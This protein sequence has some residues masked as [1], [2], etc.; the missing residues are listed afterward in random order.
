MQTFQVLNSLSGALGWTATATTLVGSNWLSISPTSGVT[1]ST[2]T[3][4][5]ASASLAKGIYLGNI[6][7]TAL[8]SANP[9]NSPQSLLVALAVSAPV[10]GQNG[11]VDGAGFAS[12]I[13]SGG[14]ASLFGTNL[15]A[16]TASAAAV[17]LP[18]TLGGTQV[19]VNGVPAPL[20]YVSPTQI[21]FQMP[22]E[23]VGASMAV[24]VVSGGITSLQATVGIAAA[25]PG[26]FTVNSNGQ[27]QGAVLNQDYSVNSAQ[28]PAAAGS[29]IQIFASGLG[30]TNPPIAA[31]QPGSASPLDF[32]VNT[33]VVT[34][35]GVPA[36]VL[37]SGLAPTFVGLYQVNVQVPTGTASGPASLQI[38]INGQT[39]NS[40]TV[41]IR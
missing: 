18:T 37:F 12:V 24:T 31:G 33:P 38:Q 36:T 21:N 20:F 23:P 11:I 26:I 9:I 41:A 22:P 19:L 1:P 34:I 10:I 29:V 17:P 16:S 7:I 14:I 40:A 27:G 28:N 32:T 2:L 15:A 13:S 39:S 3:V 35:A 25:G 30:L 5:A 8:T 4:S 6:T